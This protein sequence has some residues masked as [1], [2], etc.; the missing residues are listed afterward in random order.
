MD[1][2][3]K[4]AVIHMT[5]T[6]YVRFSIPRQSDDGET[7]QALLA[8]A[9]YIFREWK[10]VNMVRVNGNSW[11]FEE[12]KRERVSIFVPVQEE[13][14]DESR[15]G[16][17]ETGIES[18]TGYIDRR[19]RGDINTAKV[20]A[21]FH[22]LEKN[23]KT[24][25]QMYYNITPA[26]YILK[27]RLYLAAK[28]LGMKRDL[29][30]IL[31]KYH[32]SSARRFGELFQGE[33]HRKPEKYREMEL[34]TVNLVSYYHK[35]KRKIRVI[36]RK[37]EPFWVLGRA[38]RSQ[39]SREDITNVPEQAAMYFTEPPYPLDQAG[40]RPE[41]GQAALWDETVN[42]ESGEILYDYALG[43]VAEPWAEAPEGWKKFRLEGGWYAVFETENASDAPELAENFRLLTRC[44]FYGWIQENMYRYDGK[45]ITY[46]RYRNE[47]LEFYVP[48]NM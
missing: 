31:R 36:F 48:V 35:Y 34:D 25:F 1:Q 21:H 47:K 7:A 2:E 46:V 19:I 45:R 10:M 33:F 5:G 16:K 20:A 4:T 13:L 12:Y 32:F 8:L 29:E 15:L 17:N 38:V 14:L 9:R 43:P 18:W 26:Q 40:M 23:F 6:H 22:Y 41:R 28:E 27:R 39:R 37:E 44:A 30:T 3:Q 24:L 11:V 42:R